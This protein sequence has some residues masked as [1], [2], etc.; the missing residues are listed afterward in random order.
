[1][2][3]EDKASN[4]FKDA[5]GKVKESAGK[6][7]DN[8]EL[9]GEGKG[10]QA[11]ASHQGRG[12]EPEGRRRQRQGRVQ[13]IAERVPAHFQLVHSTSPSGLDRSGVAT[14]PF[15][16]WRPRRPSLETWR[17]H[18]RP[19]AA[20]SAIGTTA[21]GRLQMRVPE[22]DGYEEVIVER[23][24][25]DMASARAWCERIVERAAPGTSY[26]RSRSSRRAGATPSPGRPP[27]PGPRPRCSSSVWST[28]PD[29]C[30]GPSPAR[31]FPAP[32]RAT[33]S[34]DAPTLR[35]A[36]ARF[37]GTMGS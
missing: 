36:V 34:E 25:P 28:A 17:K 37:R 8:E 23:R 13:E 29:A 21:L 4:K 19:C 9:E 14:P 27:R 1:M 11:E 16:R 26:W 24:W 35:L 12:G 15:V 22:D 20:N 31:W 33:S 30:A 7:T 10:D 18:R 32:V 2:G 3:V 6:A 5:K